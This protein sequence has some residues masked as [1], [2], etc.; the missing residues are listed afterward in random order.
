[1]TA[2]TV[3][4]TI[5]GYQISVPKGTLVIRAAETIGI[6][7]PRFCDHPLLDSIGACRQCLV[8]IE[9]QRKPLA[10]CTTVC[11]EGMVV[12]TQLTSAVAE[13]AQ[14]GVMELLLINHP[15]DCPMCDKG[16]ECPLQNQALANGQGE[17]RFLEEKREFDKPVPISTGVLLDRE[18]CISCTRCVRTSEE[19]AGDDFIEFIER[20]PSQYIGTAAGK[21]FN[22]YFSGNTVQVCAAGCHQR[23]D[24]RRGRVLRRLAGDEPL[25]N[26]E[27]NCD[28]GRWAFAYASQSDRLTS[29]LVRDPEGVLRPASWAAA[30][31][32]A[33][34][35]L[36]AARDAGEGPSG[37]GVLTGG[38]LTLE[39]A[40]AYAKFTRIALE[41]NDIDMRARAHSVEEEQFIAARVAGRDI[42][43]SYADLEAAPAVLLAGFE[44][45][46]ESPIVFLR[47]RK[48]SRKTAIRV[49][50]VAAI[51]SP[52]LQKMAGT[53]LPTVPGAEPG[54]LTALAAGGGSDSDIAAAAGLLAKPGAVILVGERLAEVPGALAAAVRL[55]EATGAKLAWVPRRAGERGAIEAGAMPGLLPIGRWVGD[56]KARAEVALAWNKATLPATPGR[57]TGALL[58]AAEAG[59]LAALVI[60]GVDVAD[61][62]DPAAALRALDATPFIVSLELRA[63]AVTDRADVVFPVAAVAEKAG[64]FVNW[65]GRGASFNAALSVPGVRTDLYV[66]GAIADEMDVHLGLPDAAAARAELVALGAWKGAHPAAPAVLS[67]TGSGVGEGGLRLATWH[68]LID[69][70]RLQDGEPYLA[71]T[72]RPVVAR[73][74]AATAAAAGLA[75]GDKV[76]VTTAAGSV[77]VPLDVT[78]MADGVVWL[79][80]NSPGSAVR[81][82]LAAGHGSRVSLRRA[83]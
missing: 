25:V 14:R 57:S 63:S 34:R 8:E 75:D 64:T 6:A 81:A 45:E 7:I 17:S 15:L 62:P 71:G 5:D 55:A 77:T 68:Q 26:E 65:E 44:P 83:E 35:G 58:A 41:T 59:E 53:L 69:A 39:D 48:A 50:S 4:V 67:S 79:P 9:G 20:G 73:V 43:V 33:A 47:L 23:T 46:D 74:S 2:E 30:Y 80:A 61:L 11:T 38:R 78:E 19:I 10:S 42:E 66:L 22:S 56:P 24:H 18:R 21:P 27:W 52:G 36:A 13:K 37:A 49:F 76:T 1:M 16:G 54:T 82:D 51:A 40:Y 31:A 28:K 70:G 32:A 29:P 72:A 3:N 12:K 60:A